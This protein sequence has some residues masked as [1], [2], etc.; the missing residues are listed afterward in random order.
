MS[1]HAFYLIADRPPGFLLL[2][3]RRTG[4]VH[5]IRADSKAPHLTLCG[6]LLNLTASRVHGTEEAVADAC[7][8]CTYLV[9]A[10]PRPV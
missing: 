8:N 4:R 2:R 7:P 10:E 5:L 6:L 9:N 1:A 3:S